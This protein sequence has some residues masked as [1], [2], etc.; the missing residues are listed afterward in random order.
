[1]DH[2][3]EPFADAARRFARDVVAPRRAQLDS[4]GPALDAVLAAAGELGLLSLGAPAAVGGLE[5][6]LD[7]VCAVLRPI[8]RAD[9][10]VAVAL[11]VQ[12]GA[13][14]LLAEG[15]AWPAAVRAGD[16]VTWPAFDGAALRP[17]ADGVAA[18]VDGAAALVPLASRARYLVATTPAEIVCCD[19]G[20]AAR[21]PA[22]VLGL[23]ACAPA[24]L[25]LV[26]APVT[27]RAPAAA[28]D[29]L[30]A[31]SSL[32]GTAVALGLLEGCFATALAYARQRRQGGRRIIEWPEV[33]RM[34]ARLRESTA[35]LA[36]ALAGVLA[37]RRGGAPAWRSDAMALLLHA[38][39]SARTG[40]ADGVQLLGGNGYMK[41]FPQERRMRDARQLRCL[42]GAAERRGA[43]AFDAW[44]AEAV[45]WG[46]GD[47]EA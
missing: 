40:T 46:D 37:A 30:A 19:L 13:Q 9:A 44:L 24:D 23:A 35:L 32:A 45:D 43:A 41:D 27:W 26:A 34:L 15:G 47:P 10:G 28:A 21:R 8:A 36:A 25:T 3:I 11:L 29:E 17:A 33:R 39:E 5:L 6:D 4:D 22:P 20:G 12:A 1:M 42:L 16:L 14:R 18:R 31:W 2:E 38:T 7:V